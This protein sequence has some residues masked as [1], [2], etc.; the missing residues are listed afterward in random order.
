MTDMNTDVFRG[1]GV[2]GKKRRPR[3]A[4]CPPIPCC[5]RPYRR[6]S[7]PSICPRRNLLRFTGRLPSLFDINPLVWL[8]NVDGVI[9]DARKAPRT[10]QELAFEEG[11]IP[12]IPADRDGSQPDE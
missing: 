6:A 5:N 12:Y 11:L 8:L 7:R 4:G 3:T 9:M 1:N 2:A 10:I